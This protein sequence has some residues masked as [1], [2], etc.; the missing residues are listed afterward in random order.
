MAI[1]G[2]HILHVSIH[3]DG[4]PFSWDYNHL[5][6]NVEIKSGISELCVGVRLAE[7]TL[8]CECRVKGNAA[9]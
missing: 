9:P 8:L 1:C 5:M 3:K 2:I 7:R 4:A 6:T